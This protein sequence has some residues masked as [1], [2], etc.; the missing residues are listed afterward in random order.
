MMRLG[1]SESTASTLIS[2]PPWVTTGR[3]FSD[4]S[5]E[6][7]VRP[8]MFSLK[9]SPRSVLVYVPYMS[10]AT[11]RETSS[12][13]TALPSLSVSSTGSAG[14]GF[15][16]TGSTSS[17]ALTVD[18]PLSWRGSGLSEEF[19]SSEMISEFEDS[20]SALPVSH[21]EQPDRARDVTASAATTARRRLCW[22]VENMGY[23]EER[24]CRKDSGLRMLGSV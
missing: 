1:R 23:L 20:C 22:D 11:M 15:S 14:S 9:P 12:T 10:R 24:Q 18:T 3:S 21:E 5:L 19:S 16:A 4:S 2:W 6:E 8:T 17:K 7:L 13:L